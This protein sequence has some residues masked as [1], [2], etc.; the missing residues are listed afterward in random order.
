MISELVAFRRI[1]AEKS[2]KLSIKI[3]DLD[4]EANVR[5][6]WKDRRTKVS[7]EDTLNYTAIK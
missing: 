4:I 5:Y 2:L 6:F 7:I 3:I 1:L